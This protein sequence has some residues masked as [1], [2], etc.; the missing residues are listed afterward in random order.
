[1]LEAGR[2]G[3]YGLSGMRERAQQVGAKLEIW[4]GAKAG[5][6]IDLSIAGSIAYRTSTSRVPFRLF[7]RKK[8]NL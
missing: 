8:V 4:S 7:R 6:E 5:T 3:H 2:S 1:M